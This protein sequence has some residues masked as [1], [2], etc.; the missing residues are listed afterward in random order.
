MQCCEHDEAEGEP[1]LMQLMIFG[2]GTPAKG[3]VGVEASYE[4]R[5][6]VASCDP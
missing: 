3:Q 4:V 5:Y 6:Q 1:E 2:N